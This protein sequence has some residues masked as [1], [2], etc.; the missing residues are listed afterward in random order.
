MR[1]QLVQLQFDSTSERNLAYY[2]CK[3]NGLKATQVNE[4]WVDVEDIT[5]DQLNRLN[6]IIDNLKY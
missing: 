2:W 6:V 1:I 4:T 5:I 3:A